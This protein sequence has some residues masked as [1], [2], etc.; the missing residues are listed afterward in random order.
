MAGGTLEPAEHLFDSFGTLR[1]KQDPIRR[2]QLQPAQPEDDS[3]KGY[4]WRASQGY[5]P[6]LRDIILI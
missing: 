2:L 5:A 4:I 1:Q 6:S 3:V